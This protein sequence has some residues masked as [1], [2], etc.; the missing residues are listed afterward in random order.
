MKQLSA[1]IW[2]QKTPAQ[3]IDHYEQHEIELDK[4]H[5]FVP[6]AKSASSN[7]V[8]EMHQA[9]CGGVA[10]SNWRETDQQAMSEAVKVLVREFQQLFIEED[11]K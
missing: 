3:K 10:I 8:L 11:N 7:G 1:H 9:L 4:K 5:M 6:G 2:N